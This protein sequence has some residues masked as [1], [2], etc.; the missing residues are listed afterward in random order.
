MTTVSMQATLLP[1]SVPPNVE[2]D[3][4]IMVDMVTAVKRS[5]VGIGFGG[6]A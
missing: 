6:D 3:S 2:F 4:Q 1:L 5:K